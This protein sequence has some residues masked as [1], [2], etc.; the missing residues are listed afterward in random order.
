MRVQGIPPVEILVVAG[1]DAPAQG[2]ADS[3]VSFDVLFAPTLD[4]I[5]SLPFGASIN[6]IAAA[7]QIVSA[8]EMCCSL[9]SRTVVISG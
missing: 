3:Q 9:L 5:A 1:G 2:P 6:H 7:V 8:I 4:L